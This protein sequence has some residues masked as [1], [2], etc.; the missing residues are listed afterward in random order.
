MKHML[1]THNGFTG[2]ISASIG[3]L[4]KINRIDFTSNHLSG[5]IVP[6]IFYERDIGSVTLR[7]NYFKESVPTIGTGI[8]RHFK[9]I[10]FQENILTGPVASN[11]GKLPMIWRFSITFNHLMGTIS[12]DLLSTD[13]SIEYLMLVDNEL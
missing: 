10:N 2:T 12:Q 7:S 13:S 3:S 5:T 6:E 1:F 9:W 8:A 4:S 11:L